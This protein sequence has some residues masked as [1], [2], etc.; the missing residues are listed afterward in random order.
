MSL[1]PGWSPASYPE[2]SDAASR[3]KGRRNGPLSGP[4][5]L[6]T[7]L[8]SGRKA[9]ELRH[10]G[11]VS[12]S[13]DDLRI[14]A[15]SRH[16]ARWD[17][18]RAATG[19]VRRVRR[20][21][22][23][24]IA[25]G[26]P[27]CK[28]R[29]R[30]SFEGARLICLRS[31]DCLFYSLSKMSD[32]KKTIEDLAADFAVSII[33]AL[34]SASIDELMAL[35][36]AG[37]RPAG[38]GGRPPAVELDGRKRGRAGRLGRRSAEDIGQMVESIVALLQKKPEGLRAEQIRDALAVQAKELPRPLSD[39]LAAGR[40]KKTGQKR[41]TTYFVGEGGAAGGGPTKRRGSRR[42]RG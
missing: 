28:A 26:V 24:S 15:V 1:E 6:S 32:L 3:A 20:R 29:Q 9:V 16:C 13:L 10:E 30:R 25:H 5:L 19:V 4:T 36:G 12:K 17:N 35:G 37:G 38:R 42:R 18:H 27:G 41:A 22:A 33:G 23:S 2:E 14:Q 7:R 40:I 31:C 21:A 8:P 34:R 39:A 11:R